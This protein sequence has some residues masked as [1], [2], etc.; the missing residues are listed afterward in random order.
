MLWID[1]YNI[2]SYNTV[3]HELKKKVERLVAYKDFPHTMLYGP[4]ENDI[5]CIA[6]HMVETIYGSQ[7][8][9][10]RKYT[11]ERKT[12]SEKS[13]E[14]VSFTLFRSNYHFEINLSDAGFGDLKVVQSILSDLASTRPLNF[15]FKT[16]IVYNVDTINNEGQQA[17]RK[18]IENY[19]LTCR[20]IFLSS[21]LTRV[22]PTLRSRCLEIRIPSPPKEDI[23]SMLIDVA[24][25]ESIHLPE[26]LAHKI[27]N[28]SSLDMEQALLIFEY[29]KNHTYPFTENQE[30]CLAEWYTII[31]NIVS[32]FDEVFQGKKEKSILPSFLK[33]RKLFYKLL[34]VC[35]PYNDFLK[36]LLNQIL[37]LELPSDARYDIIQKASQCN[38]SIVKGSKA[39]FHLEAFSAF[40]LYR[41][42]ELI[43]DAT[44]H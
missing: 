32:V 44:D 37:K 26:P 17:L 42:N 3:I 10:M 41:L 27:V 36:E 4:C 20:W 39:I 11:I 18:I 31:K 38:L 8:R 15:E 13:N 6:K 34:L 7:T 40:A 9:Y 30:P 14:K 24:K 5:I 1:T 33:I 28:A 12:S 21:S 22:C 25:K 16:F 29:T 23:F 43:P 19:S 2:H 35:I